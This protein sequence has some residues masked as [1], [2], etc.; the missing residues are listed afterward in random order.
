MLFIRY[1]QFGA[2]NL[3]PSL[4]CPNTSRSD[5]QIGVQTTKR[6]ARMHDGVDRVSVNGW[7]GISW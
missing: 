5:E 6:I 7:F 4:R 3:R 1:P 2:L